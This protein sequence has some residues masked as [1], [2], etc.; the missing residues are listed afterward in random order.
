MSSQV[1]NI[2]WKSK[3]FDKKVSQIR[4]SQI[5][6]SQIRASQIRATEISSNHRELHGAFF[7]TA[8]HRWG[9][10][11]RVVEAGRT[12]EYS[13]PGLHSNFCRMW[14]DLFLFG[15]QAKS[16][17]TGT[18]CDL[19]FFGLSE[20]TK[21]WSRR[22]VDILQPK[23]SSGETQCL[24]RQSQ[25]PGAVNALGIAC[26]G[27]ANT[28]SGIRQ[29]KGHDVKQIQK[30]KK[31]T[32]P[33]RVIGAACV[34]FSRFP[35][36]SRF[37]NPSIQQ[38]HIKPPNMFSSRLTTSK[39]SVFSDPRALTSHVFKRVVPKGVTTRLV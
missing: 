3:N 18:C 6:V 15:K 13:F 22:D 8:G 32:P 17:Y 26:S 36:R 14:G 1:V 11:A 28:G 30:R 2:E 5:R 38:E 23:S 31:N 34:F 10:T 16:F 27:A 33:R 19:V 4:A 24:K 7:Y 20:V 25:V 12:L 39:P 29:D 9:E 21:F 37:A 35:C